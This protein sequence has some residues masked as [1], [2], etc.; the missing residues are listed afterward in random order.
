MK[1]NDTTLGAIEM[2]LTY[3]RS[4][5]HEKECET[6]ILL[7]IDMFCKVFQRVQID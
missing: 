5:K 1:S 6:K 4:L 2:V 3:L 7:A